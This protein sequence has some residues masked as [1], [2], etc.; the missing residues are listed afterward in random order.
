[1]KDVPIDATHISKCIRIGASLSDKLESAVVGF[2][3]ANHDVFVW[4]P[5]NMP[6]I[7]REVVEHTL[8]IQPMARLVA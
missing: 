5:T 2:L 1:M 4:K 6:K 3:Q 7:P 8:N